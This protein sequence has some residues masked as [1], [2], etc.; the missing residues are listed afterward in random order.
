M[1]KKITGTWYSITAVLGLGTERAVSAVVGGTG[2]GRHPRGR[3]C[4]NHP[5]LPAKVHPLRTC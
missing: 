2:G 1:V 5:R 3:S 4:I